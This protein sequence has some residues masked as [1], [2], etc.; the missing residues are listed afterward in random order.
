LT[1]GL[2]RTVTLK[3]PAKRVVSLAP[4][5]TELLYEVGAGA[6]VVGVDD[7][8]DFPAEV[9]TLP[10]VGGSKGSYDLKAI[11]ALKPDLVLVAQINTPA[12]VQSLQ[13]RGLTVFYLKN[14]EHR[15]D[16]YTNLQAVGTLMG[17]LTRLPC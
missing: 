5:D 9:A 15:V 11:A 6:Q 12:L 16:L 13:D 1:D 7:F 2:N 14:P 17:K 10:K 3:G 4:S 8:S